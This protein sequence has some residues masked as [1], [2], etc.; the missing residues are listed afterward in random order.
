[1]TLGNSLSYSLSGLFANIVAVG[2]I[3]KKASLTA[4]GLV[5]VMKSSTDLRALSPIHLR[6]R[7]Q[8]L[9]MSPFLH[10]GASPNP[11]S[12]LPLILRRPPPALVSSFVSHSTVH[13]S[14]LS[15]DLKKRRYFCLYEGASVFDL[16][17][18]RVERVGNKQDVREARAWAAPS[19]S[20]SPEELLKSVSNQLNSH[21]EELKD[22]RE[23]MKLVKLERPMLTSVA[24]TAFREL[25]LGNYHKIRELVQNYPSLVHA[26]DGV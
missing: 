4:A 21:L 26:V 16:S 13:L 5:I 10:V 15:P 1:M 6:R 11:R 19:R 20:R 22:D 23:V 17:G 24:L 3:D 7:S 14:S 9:L 25:K 2:L 8:R 12:S 18:Q